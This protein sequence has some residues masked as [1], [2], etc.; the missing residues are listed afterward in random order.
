[1][2]DMILNQSIENNSFEE[3][4]EDV[5]YR[6]NT[7][8]FQLNTIA[9]K[10]VAAKASTILPDELKSAINHREFTVLIGLLFVDA[11]LSLSLTSC[12]VVGNIISQYTAYRFNSEVGMD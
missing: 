10:K 8:T 1:M 6:L 4:F 2:G 5:V 12:D 11:G 7:E 9:G 3:L